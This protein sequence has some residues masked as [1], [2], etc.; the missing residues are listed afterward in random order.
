VPSWLITGGQKRLPTEWEVLG[1]K[2]YFSFNEW[3]KKLAEI[4]FS[5]EVTERPT[6]KENGL[7]AKIRATSTDVPNSKIEL[8]FWGSE[9]N[10]V[11]AKGTLWEIKIEKKLQAEENVESGSI[12]RRTVN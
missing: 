6:V 7:E 12:R 1:L 11:N 10:S 5:V 8:R 9:T 3:V 2:G 4:G